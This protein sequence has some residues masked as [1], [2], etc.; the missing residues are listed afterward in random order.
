MGQES[1]RGNT[2]GALGSLLFRLVKTAGFAFDDFHSAHKLDHDI[3]TV[4]VRVN[5]DT[6]QAIIF[7]DF[8]EEV[9]FFR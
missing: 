2:V 1:A 3:D 9:L 6:A 7:Q 8:E 4:A 5:A